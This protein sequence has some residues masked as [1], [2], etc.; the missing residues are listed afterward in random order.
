MRAPFAGV[1]VSSSAEVALGT[2]WR[3]VLLNKLK[4]PVLVLLCTLLVHFAPIQPRTSGHEGPSVAQPAVATSPAVAHHCWDVESL[5]GT[6][7]L[8]GGTF[9][10]AMGQE[11]VR[12][13]GGKNARLVIIP[14]AYGATEEEGPARLIAEWTHFH[15]ASVEILHT[16]D[17]SVANDPSFVV[18]LQKAT[19]V[20]LTGGKQSRL[21]DTYEDT[22]V[23]EELRNVL[24]RSGVVAGNC[25][26]AMALGELTIM[27]ASGEPV[28]SARRGLGIVPNLV[29]DSHCFE[30]NRVERLRHVIEE[31]ADCFGLGIDRQTA[32]VI[33]HGQLRVVGNS[34][35]ATLVPAPAPQDERIDIWASGDEVDMK[36]DLFEPED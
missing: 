6:V 36:K 5:P 28:S 24:K 16:R 12:L 35:V 29:V 10:E 3:S 13:A 26:G 25:A 34:Y 33:Q 20:W 2:N 15:P 11:F 31:H 18:P 32:V 14:T 27:R 4:V 19:G 22:L 9:T 30:R 8:G 23:Q 7:F 1:A 17:R 21:L